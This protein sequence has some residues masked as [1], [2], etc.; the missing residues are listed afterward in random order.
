MNEIQ[1]ENA[2]HCAAPVLPD[3]LQ[4]QILRQCRLSVEARERKYRRTQRTLCGAIVAVCALQWLIVGQLDAQSAVGKG[5]DDARP[6][7][8]VATDDSATPGA[9]MAFVWSGDWRERKFA[10]SGL[11]GESNEVAR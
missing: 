4:A 1:I 10:L 7:V 3:A 9:L 11:M 2:L 5:S 6:A 8:R